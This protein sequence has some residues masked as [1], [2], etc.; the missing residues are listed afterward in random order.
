MRGK[1][2]RMLAWLDREAAM[3]ELSAILALGRGTLWKGRNVTR[4]H[5]CAGSVSL[6]DK[7]AGM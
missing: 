7:E 2:P 6:S 1:Q 3:Q 4:F 5:Q